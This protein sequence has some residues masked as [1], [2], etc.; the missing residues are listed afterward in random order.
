MIQ[1]WLYSLLSVLIVSLISLVGLF[2][3]SIK[4]EKL[5]KIILFLISFS[6]GALIGDAFI[7]LIPEAAEQ[8]G[9]G[10]GISIALVC[11]ILLFFILEKF[12][13]WRHCHEPTCKEH[14]HPFAYINLVGDAF[15]NFID[16]A[17]IGGSYLVSIPIGMATTIAV[18]LHEIPQEIG[19]FSVLIHGGFKVKKAIAM[20]FLTALTAV[21]G[22]IVSLLIGPLIENYTK[23]LILFTAGGFIYIAV[24]DLIPELHKETGLKKAL[25][26]LLGIL[27]GIAVMI[28]FILL[29]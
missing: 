3:L 4:I 1:I 29:E 11:G 10:L 24:A 13:H 16:G 5:R 19:D 8:S 23:F 28:A 7:H 15:H 2:T 17:V 14:P 21:L 25:T 27:L 6:A 26:Q 18:L 20:N 9:F 22:C 12:I